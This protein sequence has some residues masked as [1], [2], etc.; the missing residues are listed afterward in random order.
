ME[1]Q[2][3]VEPSETRPYKHTEIIFELLDQRQVFYN[4]TR[5]FVE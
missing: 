4:D 3:S 1:G 2:Y 5:R